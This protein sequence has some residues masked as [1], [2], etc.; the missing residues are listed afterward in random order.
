MNAVFVR[1]SRIQTL[2]ITRGSPLTWVIPLDP[3]R[4]RSTSPGRAVPGLGI[5]PNTQY[6]IW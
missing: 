2:S 6:R 1:I 3:V 4:Q 5:S